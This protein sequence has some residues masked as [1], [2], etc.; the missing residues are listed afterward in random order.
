MLMPDY[1]EYTD[2]PISLEHFYTRYVNS[3]RKPASH[4]NPSSSRAR[5][6]RP[7]QRSPNK[8]KQRPDN[9]AVNNSTT[10]DDTKNEYYS[11]TPSILFGP[12]NKITTTPPAHTNQNHTRPSTATSVESQIIFQR[13]ISKPESEQNHRTLNLDETTTI[14]AIFP[15][16]CLTGTWPEHPHEHQGLLSRLKL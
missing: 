9:S 5:S 2:N 11:I 14:P 13:L 6:Q 7:D 12:G 8:K 15:K 1:Y 10:S 4:T 3:D 16:N